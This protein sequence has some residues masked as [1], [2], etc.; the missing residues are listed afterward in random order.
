[1]NKF[2]MDS[3]CDS[4]LDRNE[5]WYPSGSYHQRPPLH[6]HCRCLSVA[7][8]RSILDMGGEVAGATSMRP[9][10]EWAMDAGVGYDGGLDALP[11]SSKG[12]KW[13]VKVPRER[14]PKELGPAAGM[15]KARKAAYDWA[16]RN[17]T[18]PTAWDTGARYGQES[19]AKQRARAA[20]VVLKENINGAR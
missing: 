8:A 16:R 4:C 11:I 10:G 6:R 19:I 17:A 18:L 9:Y 13:R 3:V 20:I 1:V 12:G 2:S 14:K 7:K 15:S 5:R